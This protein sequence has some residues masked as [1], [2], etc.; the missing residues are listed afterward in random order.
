MKA[1]SPIA[2][3]QALNWMTANTLSFAGEEAGASQNRRQIGERG[4]VP[5]PP[6]SSVNLSAGVFTLPHARDACYGTR[7]R[8]NAAGSK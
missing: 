8:P 4:A 5:P 2:G 7:Q 1:G 3:L 6:N